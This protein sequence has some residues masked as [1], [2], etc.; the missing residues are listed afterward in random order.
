M[1]SA[2]LLVLAVSLSAQ[3]R[4]NRD[5]QMNCENNNNNDWRQARSC[6]IKEQTVAAVGRLTVDAGHNG[7]VTVKGWAQGQTLVRAQVE[8]WAPS[9]SEASLLAGPVN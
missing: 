3:M 1:K 9:D 4:D 6:N 8:A 7:G 2:F 5:K